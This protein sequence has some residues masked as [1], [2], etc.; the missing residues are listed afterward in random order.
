M[1]EE[2]LKIIPL[3]AKIENERATWWKTFQTS[4]DLNIIDYIHRLGWRL[5]FDNNK[6]G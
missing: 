2:D 3:H 6:M 5:I 4:K 1:K